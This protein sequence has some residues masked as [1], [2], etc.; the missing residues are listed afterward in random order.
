MSNAEKYTTM[1]GSV[2]AGF[3]VSAV[4]VA[5]WPLWL[6][7]GPWL[8]QDLLAGAALSL[9]PQRYVHAY[10]RFSVE[11]YSGLSW[12]VIIASEF[13]PAVG[14]ATVA[15]LSNRVW[16]I[17]LALFSLVGGLSLAAFLAWFDSIEP[18]RAFGR[19]AAIAVVGGLLGRLLMFALAARR[20]TRQ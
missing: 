20:L 12:A 7:A 15:M 5:L 10:A 2:A 16:P 6:L 3:A 17:A 13:A 1:P 14:G 19:S 9:L 8:I 4:L 18:L 11:L